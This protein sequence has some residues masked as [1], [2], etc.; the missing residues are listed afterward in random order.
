LTLDYYTI[1][2]ALMAAAW[3]TSDGDVNYNRVC[4]LSGDT[5]INAADLSMLVDMWLENPQSP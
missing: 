3:L 1:D 4:E 5:T 2:Y